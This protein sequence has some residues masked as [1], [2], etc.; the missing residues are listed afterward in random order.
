MKDILKTEDFT[1]PEGVTVAIKSRIIKVTGPR[2]VLNKNIRHV[3]MD[4]QLVSMRFPLSRVA[5][6]RGREG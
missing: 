2:G 4:I 5:E 3:N 1:I 6:V